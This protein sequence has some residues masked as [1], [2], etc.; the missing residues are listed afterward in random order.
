MP[1]KIQNQ[2][3]F[4]WVAYWLLATGLQNYLL[5][6]LGIDNLHNYL[7]TAV[8][9]LFFTSLSIVY[10]RD[11]FNFGLSSKAQYRG[12]AGRPFFIA[13]GLSILFFVSCLAFNLWRPLGPDQQSKILKSGFYFPLFSLSTTVTKFCDITF[14]QVLIVGLLRKMSAFEMPKNRAIWAF[15]ICFFAV[16]LPLVLIMGLFAFYFIV[17]SLFAGV[18]M[19][20]LILRFRN[21]WLLSLSL[22]LA[23]YLVIGLF[24]RHY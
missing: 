16:H 6:P 15:S 20:Y 10:F 11:Q 9:F 4:A 21:G 7:I 12:P 24:M 13:L 23:F 22:H 2:L 19:S 14:Q 8:Y 5:K 1:S 17:P 3:L 18:A